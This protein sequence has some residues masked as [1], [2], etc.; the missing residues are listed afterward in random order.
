MT[1]PPGQARIQ[2]AGTPGHGGDHC[3]GRKRAVAGKGRCDEDLTDERIE[4]WPLDLKSQAGNLATVA[5]P[6]ASLMEMLS[7]NVGWRI[8][9]HYIALPS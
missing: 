6:D 8:N 2:V 7:Q 5:S 4:A 3:R 9:E 1:H